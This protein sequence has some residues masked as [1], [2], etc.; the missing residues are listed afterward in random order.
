MGLDLKVYQYQS[1]DV[2]ELASALTGGKVVAL[3]V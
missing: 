2:K 3:L 1:G